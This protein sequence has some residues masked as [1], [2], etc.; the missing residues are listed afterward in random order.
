MPE[1]IQAGPPSA[2]L[3]FESVLDDSPADMG[4]S[5]C[6]KWLAAA[7]TTG[8]VH[9]I[10]PVAG[11][12]VNA[13]HAHNDGVLTLRWHP[14]SPMLVT[15]G[16]DG[17]VRLWQISDTAPAVLLAEIALTRDSA[18]NWIEHLHWRPDGRQLAAAH[19]KN[20]VLLT[21]DCQPQHEYTFPGG[22]V[23]AMCWRP[24]GAQLAAAGYGGV[25]IYNV[26]DTRSKVQDINWKG[27]LLSLNWSP[28]AR[29]I[30]AGCQD[31]TVHFWRLPELRDAM[32][33]GF[34]YKP[35][36]LNW[37]NN[38]RWLLTG[39]SAELIMWPFD[40]KGPEGRAP[41][42]ASFHQDAICA[43]DIAASG[44]RLATGCRAGTIAF[45]NQIGDSQP[46]MTAQ[47]DSRT[48]HLAWAPHKNTRLLASTSRYGTLSVW[49]ASVQ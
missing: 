15:S 6:G 8:I 19:G 10:D 9:L 3:L 45:W 34:A 39:G 24:K 46:G 7:A 11:I 36:Q 41:L 4:W 44:Q 18:N 21:A 42:T 31:N 5:S 35:V 30:A 14:T 43:I 33:S 23:G 26:L 47:L 38:S 16:K 25:R 40:K 17:H 20:I 48:E 1:L 13:W 29:V 49:D 32:M 22:T 12:Q 28:D 2:R 27:S 37:S